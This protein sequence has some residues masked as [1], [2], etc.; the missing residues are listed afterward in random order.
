MTLLHRKKSEFLKEIIVSQAIES[1]VIYTYNTRP[2]DPVLQKN[3]S[4]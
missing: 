1:I 2:S 3:V 4:V